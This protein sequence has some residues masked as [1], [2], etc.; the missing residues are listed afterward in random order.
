MWEELEHVHGSECFPNV[1]KLATVGRLSAEFS[2][3]NRIKTRLRNA[4]SIKRLDILMKIAINGPTRRDFDRAFVSLDRVWEDSTNSSENAEEVAIK[5]IPSPKHAQKYVSHVDMTEFQM[6]TRTLDGKSLCLTSHWRKGNT[7]EERKYIVFESCLLQLFTICCVCFSE[8]VKLNLETIS[9]E[10][11][12]PDKPLEERKYTGGKEIHSIPR[13][14][15][16]VFQHLKCQSVSIRTF[17]RHQQMYLQSSIRRVWQTQQERLLNTAQQPLILGGDGCADSP[18][19]S[20]KYG[21]YTMMDLRTS[22]ILTIHLVQQGREKAG[23]TP[24]YHEYFERRVEPRLLENFWNIT[25][26][27]LP[28]AAQKMDKSVLLADDQESD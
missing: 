12:V 13:Q 16:N 4:L 21:A 18:G 24:V 10:V 26:H 3:Q 6:R 23:E 25:A 27:R 15:L 20:A 8:D 11:P 1:L 17:F 2:I 19:H 22:R 9:G 5:D 7:L 14:A 28:P